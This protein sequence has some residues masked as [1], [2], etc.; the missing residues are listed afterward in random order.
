MSN[1]FA[2]AGGNTFHSDSYTTTGNGVTVSAP[3]P[4]SNFALQC[5]SVGGIATTWTIILEG[6]IDGVTFSTLITHTNITGD[7]V[8]LWTSTPAPC[9]SFRSRCSSLTLGPATSV[10]AQ[11]LAT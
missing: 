10:T 1:N 9:R 11:V 7:S 5:I 4:A 2:I 6:S 8:T 3:L